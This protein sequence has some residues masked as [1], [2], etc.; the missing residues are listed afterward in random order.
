[1]TTI[2]I[3]S[4]NVYW[5]NM[6]KK[7]LHRNNTL[8]NI[9]NAVKLYKPDIIAIQEAEAI[10]KI[11]Q[12]FSPSKY[13]IMLNKSSVESMMTIYNH[14]RFNKINSYSG[15][16]EKGRP[17]CVLLL[18]DKILNENI[19]FINIHASHRTDTQKYL[20]GII[21]TFLKN[22]VNIPIDRFTICGDF[23][24]NVS[25]DTTSNYQFIFGNKKIQFKINGD[26]TNTCCDENGQH[27]LLNFDHLIDSKRVC[28]KYV[29]LHEDWYKKKSS[30]H[31]AI[32][33]VV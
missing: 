27:M 30:D 24:R 4:Y 20:I 2:T 18:N 3:L 8:L 10:T 22:N 23:N 12:I 32:L 29:L 9:I 33:F 26:Q 16:F 14:K 31:S 28:N 15:E 11:S 1:M 6:I 21:N 7:G 17:F 5:K 19:C 25:I 13:K